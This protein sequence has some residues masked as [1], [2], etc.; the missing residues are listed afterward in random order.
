MSDIAP[1]PRGRRRSAPLKFAFAL[2]GAYAAYVLVA[3]AAQKSTGKPLPLR[4]GDVG[5]FLLV[6]AATVC[7]VAGV[8]RLEPARDERGAWA[9]L[10]AN[11]ERYAMLVFYVLCCFVIVQEVLRRFVLNYSSAWAEEIARYAFIY[12]GYVGTAYAVKE[13][14]HIRFDIL[15]GR[16]PDRARALLYALAEIATI[17]FA[18]VA[19]WWSMHTVAQLLRFEGTTPVLRINKVWFEAAVPIGFALVVLRCLQALKRDLAD[20]AAGRPPWT[21]KSM[22]EE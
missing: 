16:V 7:F 14:A 15:I 20:F 13:R 4:L 10:D 21:G 12:L 9:L 8:L 11:G 5:E 22:F 18:A 6:L 1:T 17:A 3:A 2:Y 19:F